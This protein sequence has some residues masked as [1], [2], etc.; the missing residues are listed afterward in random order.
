[1]EGFDAGWRWFA[2]RLSRDI[3]REIA[4]GIAQDV[5]REVA[6]EL[7]TELKRQLYEGHYKRIRS[8]RRMSEKLVYYHILVHQPQSFT[9]IRRALNIGKKTLD[10]ALRELK[11]R[12]YVAQD[13]QYLYWVTEL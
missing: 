6:V 5:V 10:R 9:S 13:Q 8:L 7:A 1:L 2:G 12:G 3:A 11:E 4:R